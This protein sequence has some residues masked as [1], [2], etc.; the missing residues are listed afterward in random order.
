M[1]TRMREKV[2]HDYE[3]EREGGC[4]KRE[5]EREGECSKREENTHSSHSFKYSFHLILSICSRSFFP[6]GWIWI[7]SKGRERESNRNRER[8]ER[9]DPLVGENDVRREGG[10]HHVNVIPL[11]L[12]SSE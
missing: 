3:D 9:L 5:D 12:N 11:L 7:C 1:I 4:L 2:N 8:E 10:D 6:E